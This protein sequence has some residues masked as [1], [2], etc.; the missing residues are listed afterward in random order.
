MSSLPIEHRRTAIVSPPHE[1]VNEMSVLLNTSTT[2]IY[3]IIIIVIVVII[4]M[5]IIIIIL[6]IVIATVDC[7]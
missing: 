3:I 5:I 6:M 1:N 7:L 4:I 2:E